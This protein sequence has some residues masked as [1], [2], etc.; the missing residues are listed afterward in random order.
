MPLSHG[1]ITALR[2][3]AELVL[4][5][6]TFPLSMIDYDSGLAGRRKNS[7]TKPTHFCA[8]GRIEG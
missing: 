6:L 2:P 1:P 5:H 3:Q 7:R 4:T 8:D